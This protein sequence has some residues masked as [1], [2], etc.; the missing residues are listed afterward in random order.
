VW[1]WFSTPILALVIGWNGF[2]SGSSDFPGHPPQGEHL[3]RRCSRW[4]PRREVAMGGVQKGR[5]AEGWCSATGAPRCSRCAP[6]PPKVLH[7]FFGFAICSMYLGASICVPSVLKVRRRSRFEV[8]SSS[9][10]PLSRSSSLG[11][12]LTILCFVLTHG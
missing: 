5:D 4:V 1:S 9:C 2:P 6:P 12:L 3:T 10:L 8:F 11:R 7:L